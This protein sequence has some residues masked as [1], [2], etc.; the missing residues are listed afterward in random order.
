[1]GYRKIKVTIHPST[2]GKQYRIVKYTTTRYWNDN[3]VKYQKENN[4]G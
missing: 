4:N 2:A 1:M 3:I